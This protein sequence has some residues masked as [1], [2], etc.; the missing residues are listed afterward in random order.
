MPDISN[1][2]SYCDVKANK[3]LNAFNRRSPMRLGVQQ[4]AYVPERASAAIKVP[5]HTNVICELSDSCQAMSSI[6]LTPG[7]LVALTLPV[8]TQGSLLPFYSGPARGTCSDWR[9]LGKNSN[10][11]AT[12]LTYD[13]LAL[14]T[15]A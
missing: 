9:S 6:L 13:Q 11:P 7:S 8:I 14:L 15:T 3:E 12:S 1:H 4:G 10:K 5:E 2:Q